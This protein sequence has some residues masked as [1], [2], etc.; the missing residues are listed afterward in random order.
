MNLQARWITPTVTGGTYTMYG[1]TLNENGQVVHYGSTPD[2]VDP[3][4]YQT[5]VYSAKAESVV[6]ARAPLGKP[7]Y[8]WRRPL[9]PPR[10][11]GERL[12]LH[13][14][15]PAR[16]ASPAEGDLAGEAL[17]Q[18]P[19]FNKA[20]VSD[21]TGEIQNLTLMGPN[22]IAA[23]GN[24]YRA[25]LESL[26]AVDEMVANLVDA[27]KDTGKLIAPSSSSPRTT[28]SSTGSTGSE[29]ERSGCTRNRCG[30]R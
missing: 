6:R 7:F 10:G 24:R 28:A 4:T 2:V 26:L 27:L 17:P 11:G 30:S 29:T 15:Q 14:Q 25:R 8:L 9:R 21:K 20:D 22:Q 12:R 23:A 16:G 3:A 13:R 19:N 1:Y 5:D 18:P